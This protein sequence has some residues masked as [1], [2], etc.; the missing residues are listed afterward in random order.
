MYL[1]AEPYDPRC[2]RKSSLPMS[3]RLRGC[4]FPRPDFVNVFM[5][6]FYQ[7]VYLDIEAIRQP[8]SRNAPGWHRVAPSS[9]GATFQ[10]L[11][12]KD[13]GDVRGRR[14]SV[15]ELRDFLRQI[16]RTDRG[17]F[18]AFRRGATDWNPGLR[19]PGDHHPHAPLRDRSS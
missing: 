4:P 9:A 8:I 5:N 19:L 7:G 6:G 2:S 16:N 12:G 1:K 10:H 15:E 13:P 17:E 18:E 3:S 14:G 11:D